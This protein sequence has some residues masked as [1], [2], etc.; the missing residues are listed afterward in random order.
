MSRESAAR[1]SKFGQWT[2]AKFYYTGEGG[3]AMDYDAR[4]TLWRLVAAQNYDRAQD[5]PVSNFQCAEEDAKALVW[6][7]RAASQWHSRALHIV[8]VF[9]EKSYTRAL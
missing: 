9:Y 7:M 4:V 1:G 8:G 3:V 2:L 6:F 5:D